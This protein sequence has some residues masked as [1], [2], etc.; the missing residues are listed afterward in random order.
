LIL[1]DLRKVQN[2]E[3]AFSTVP[4]YGLRETCTSMDTSKP[5]QLVWTSTKIPGLYKHK[6]GSY[7]VRTYAVGKQKWPTFQ[8]SLRS[9]AK[10]R[11]KEHSE[12]SERMR[13]PGGNLEMSS[14][15]F[16]FHFLG[17]D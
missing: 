13:S 5:K 8:T 7:Y 4:F 2:L 3:N 10:I 9:V 16:T 14:E 17:R 11:M 6:T 15:R 1:N 12:A